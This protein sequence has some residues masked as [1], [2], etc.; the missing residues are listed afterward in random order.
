MS[1]QIEFP[2]PFELLPE[3]GWRPAERRELR[4]F[5]APV[6]L[7]L[8]PERRSRQG[9]PSDFRPAF[10][11]N[12]AERI[13]REEAI[14]HGDRVVLTPN[15]FAFAER[16]ALLWTTT[17]HREAPE[18]LLESGFA[19]VERH[20]GTALGNSIGAAASIQRAHLHLAADEL[21]FLDAVEE[22]DF[23]LDG[24]VDEFD[25][26]TKKLAGVPFVGVG[27]RGSARERARATARLIELRMTATFTLLARG[28]TTWVFPRRAE[29]PAPHFPYAVGA[30]E[31]WG[32]WCYG[33]AEP[34]AAATSEA[35]ER[36]LVES[37]VVTAV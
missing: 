24:L 34:L 3:T 9:A 18:H 17:P 12:P 26:E 23:A 33:D 11:A 2:N 16:H 32:R 15:K 30:A 4:V 27:V 20:G 7:L 36:A 14:W 8:L 25:V 22:Q 35:L 13:M 29:T 19:M 37:T 31:Y 28:D 5:G 10:R 21:P 1:A 6:E